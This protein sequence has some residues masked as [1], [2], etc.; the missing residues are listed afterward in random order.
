[1]TDTFPLAAHPRLLVTITPIITDPVEPAVNEMLRVPAP[2][3]IAPLTIDQEYEAATP[4]SGTDAEPVEPGAAFPDVEIEAAGR[5]L[6]PINAVEI[7]VQPLE[8]VIVT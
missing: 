8:F 6:T 4:A 3:V 2:V 1:M 5:M 7:L